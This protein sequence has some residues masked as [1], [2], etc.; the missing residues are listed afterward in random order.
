MRYYHIRGR[1]RGFFGGT[2]GI[3]NVWKAQ[4]YCAFESAV[5]VLYGHS[6]TQRRRSEVC[7]L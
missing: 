1:G 5:V 4:D 7:G 2:I 3:L 6:R